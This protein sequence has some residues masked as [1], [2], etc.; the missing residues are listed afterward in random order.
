[1]KTMILFAGVGLVLGTS[2]AQAQTSTMAMHGTSSQTKTHHAFFP[3]MG[4]GDGYYGG[5]GEQ[6]TNPV[7]GIAYGYAKLIE[8]AGDGLK[9]GADAALTL[10]EV[11]R[12]E[13]DNWK[14][15]LETWLEV[16]K[17]N[18]DARAAARGRP[19]TPADYIRMAQMGKPRRL[20]PSQLNLLTGEL[21][22]PVVL[23]GTLFESYRQALDGLFAER[24]EHGRLSGE[25]YAQAQQTAQAM[26]DLLRQ[27]IGALAPADY[28]AARRF[29]ES[30]AYELRMPATE[31]EEM[32]TAAIIRPLR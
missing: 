2:A 6:A 20:T 21:A 19:L 25:E 11:R 32:R 13:M 3:G 15:S 12:R 18:Q 30:V 8:S 1:M 5:Y 29:L 14:K 31:G 9:N 22:W 4:Y 16:E 10:S 17:I 24:S 28:M 23:E 27:R 26:G 7:Q